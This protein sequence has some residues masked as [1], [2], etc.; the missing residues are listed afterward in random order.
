MT[1]EGSGLGIEVQLLRPN[2][3][4]LSELCLE[5]FEHLLVALANVIRPIC[6]DER[7]GVDLVLDGRSEAISISP[8]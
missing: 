3:D 5:H 4:K 2:L 8:T 1:S 6:K 7:R